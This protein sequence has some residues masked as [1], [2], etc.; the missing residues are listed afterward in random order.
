MFSILTNSR[1]GFLAIINLNLQWSI[2]I[3]GLITT[4]DKKVHVSI[5]IEVCWHHTCYCRCV[6]RVLSRDE[7][8]SRERILFVCSHHIHTSCW[9]RIKVKYMYRYSIFPSQQFQFNLSIGVGEHIQPGGRMPPHYR[10]K[11]NYYF[12]CNNF[13]W[14]YARGERMV[15]PNNN[16]M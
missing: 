9:E 5:S 11:A 15:T 6:S 2:L 13:V 7:S 1:I 3:P 4:S 12:R 14:K 8:G 10:I 16:I